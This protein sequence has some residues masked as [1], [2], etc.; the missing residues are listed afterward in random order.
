MAKNNL[1]D[2]SPI[3]LFYDA[4]NGGLK[5][6][7]I[8]LVTAKKGLGKTA[9][10][11]QFGMDTLFDGN[12]LVH[13]SF[14]QHASNIIPWYDDIFTEINKKKVITNPDAVKEQITRN[15]SI[16]NFNQDCFNLE[17]VV[18][19]LNAMKAGGYDIKSVIID[20]VDFKKMTLAD[21]QTVS[22]F[23]KAT[24]SK[25]WISATVDGDELKDSLPKEMDNLVNIVVHLKSSGN[26]TVLDVLKCSGKYKAS[27]KLDSKSLLITDK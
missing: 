9:V 3:R 13:V 5:A 7:E 17:K 25:V 26:A 27:L 15:R 14:N 21:L 11:V 6:G 1:I 19:Q 10:L 20:D 18:N 2:K 4:T 24:N 8:G 23:A 12:Q 22:T 16:F